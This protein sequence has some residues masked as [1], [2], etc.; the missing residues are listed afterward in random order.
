MRSLETENVHP[1]P[2]ARFGVPAAQQ[3]VFDSDDSDEPVRRAKARPKKERTVPRLALASA[4]TVAS[5]YAHQSDAGYAP[6]VW[7]MN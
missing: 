7:I 6:G 4:T 1:C 5:V 3:P 2:L